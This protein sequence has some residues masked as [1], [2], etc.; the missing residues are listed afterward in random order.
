MGENALQIVRA[1]AAS[2]QTENCNTR[3]DHSIRHVEERVE[4]AHQRVR[5]ELKDHRVQL[6]E[7]LMAEQQFW[8][9]GL[10]KEPILAFAEGNAVEAVADKIHAKPGGSVHGV[11]RSALRELQVSSSASLL[12]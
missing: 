7:A 12:A 11:P 10:S 1:A 9:L 3:A 5:A 8:R 4:A 2:A 6:E